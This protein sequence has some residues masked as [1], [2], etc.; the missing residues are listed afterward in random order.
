VIDGDNAVK[1]IKAEM[2]NKIH[3]ISQEC[4]RLNSIV[5]KKNS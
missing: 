3:Y 4:E 2:E 1:K 5:E